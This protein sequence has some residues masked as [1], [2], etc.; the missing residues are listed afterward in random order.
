MMLGKLKTSDS[1]ALLLLLG[2][3]STSF[4]MVI[5]F[6]FGSSAGSERKTELLAQAPAI[7][8]GRTEPVTSNR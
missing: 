2:S 4:G 8:S 5:S 6:Y 7:G 1:Q 3:L